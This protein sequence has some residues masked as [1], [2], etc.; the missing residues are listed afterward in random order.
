MSDETETFEQEAP[1]LSH[2]RILILMAAVIVVG[3]L[4][5]FV[6]KSPRFGFGFLIGGVLAEVNYYWLKSVVGGIFE[7]AIRD[8][9][10]PKLLIAR[11]LMRYVFL[12]S[13]VALLYFVD[14]V[15]FAAVIAGL[16]SLAVA[17][18]IEGIVRMFLIA[19]NRKEV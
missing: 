11:F 15:E 9:Q 17:V 7:K 8:G 5:G 1:K 14:A 10:R 12:A 4:F 16:V 13:A 3:T 18:T 6:F 19:F 2:R